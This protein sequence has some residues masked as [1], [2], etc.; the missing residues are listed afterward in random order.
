MVEETPNMTITVL[1]LQDAMTTGNLVSII[2]FLI[3]F[4]AMSNIDLPTVYLIILFH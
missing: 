4:S 3:Y 2:I 1:R